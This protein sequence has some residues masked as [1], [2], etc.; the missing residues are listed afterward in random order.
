MH[1]IDLQVLQSIKLI[2]GKLT[3]DFRKIEDENSAKGIYSKEK[4][5]NFSLINFII[6]AGIIY[7]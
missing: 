3:N 2:F 5:K 1:F 4:L 7:S 6:M